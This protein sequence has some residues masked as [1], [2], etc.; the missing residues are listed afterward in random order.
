MILVFGK[1]GQVG[2]KLE[3]FNNVTALGRNELDFK[4]LDDIEIII[5]EYCPSAVINA[6]AY[7]KVDQ[8]ENEEALAYT[9][10]RDAPKRIA[11]VC[12]EIDIPLVHISTD[13][14]FDGLGELDRK[15]DDITSP[16]NVYGKSKLSGEHEIIQSGAAY[17]ILRT[18]WIFSAYGKNFLKTML[19]LSEENRT[20]NV[21]NDQIGGP[22]SASDIAIACIN[23]ATQLIDFPKKSG[24]YHFTGTP[25]VSWAE[26]A[27]EIFLQSNK[28]VIVNQIST[29]LHESIADRPLNSRLDCSKTEEVYGIKLPDWRISL[30]ET[31][32]ELKI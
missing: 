10:N 12:S 19:R 26:F 14:V 15:T 16:I 6:A 32:R 24:V 5:K 31:L 21:V 17:C 1:N 25:Q 22:T 3:R 7:T 28:N 18:S 20:L 8:A 29:T 9:I 27:E 30:S 11:D 4:N 23:I 13:Y 2:R